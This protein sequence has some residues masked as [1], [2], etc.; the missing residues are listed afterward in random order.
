MPNKKYIIDSRSLTDGANTIFVALVSKTGNG[1]LYIQSLYNQGVRQFVVNRDYI[2]PEISSLE[3]IELHESADTLQYLRSEA[4]KVRQ[5]LQQPLVA[6]TGSRG[7]TM[8]KEWINIL[9][10]GKTTRSPRS[11]NSQIGVPLSILNLDRDTMNPMLLEIGISRHGEMACQE[12][13]ARPDIVVLTNVTEEHAEGFKNR[14]HQ[15]EEKLKLATRA[16]HL[17]YPKGDRE[18]EAAV[19]KL[20]ET[21]NPN[22]ATTGYSIHHDDIILDIQSGN[23]RRVETINVDFHKIESRWNTPMLQYHKNM[24][25]AAIATLSTL[26]QPLNPQLLDSILPVRTRINLREGLNNSTI[27]IDSFSN[28]ALS[29]EQPLDYASRIAAQ[30]KARMLLL[31]NNV[32]QEYKIPSKELRTI[33]A[34]AKQY[35]FNDIYLVDE[36]ADSKS[37]QG[38]TIVPNGDTLAQL[39]PPTTLDDALL[40]V[41]TPLEN[42]N[43]RQIMSL[44]EV[45]QN[46]TALEI[47]IDALIHNY[48]FF[49]SGLSKETGIICMLK[50]FGYGT[51]SVEL[52]RALE[53][54]GATALA[55]AVVDEAIELRNKG[56]KCPIIVLNP[57]TQSFDALREYNLEPVIYNFHLLNEITKFVQLNNLTN[58]PVHIKFETGMRRI[59]FL[60]EELDILADKIADAPERLRVLT[61]FSHLAT[62]DC[63]DM[64][65]YTFQQIELF[66]TMA[67]QFET[68]IGYKIKRHILNSAGILRFPQ[69]QMD[70]V[71]LGI[72]LYGIPTLPG[73]IESTLRPIASLRTTVM[74]VK[75]WNNGLT[76]GY[77]CRGKLHRDSRIATIPIGYADGLDRRLG[78]GKGF[79]VINN[80]KCPF[81]GNICMDIAM[82]DVTDVPQCEVGTSVE[83][84]GKAI[85]VNDIADVLETIPY[86][87]LTSVSKR[88]NRIYYRE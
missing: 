83:I 53:L 52:A 63:L 64:D 55:V 45:Q 86:E 78:N 41:H 72:G 23:N 10:A 39:L 40:L 68:R 4:K 36:N 35:G 51:G 42:R 18:I 57:R 74:S 80:V 54:Q 33:E 3:G 22:L 19:D 2:T 8:V 61:V 50:A 13:V 30:H 12:D 49:K 28:D 56:I 76:V 1:H 5:S 24:L 60:H 58:F 37:V 6:I 27:L 73:D 81:V 7:K 69:A 75:N 71:R 20:R 38:I 66:K 85:S 59:G 9:L 48:N 29:L 34:L 84:F 31:F 43:F 26:K 46:E 44:Y 15:I 25:G 11:Y 65:Q 32:P 21:I 88:V 47:N 17:I 70:M 79:V 77:G 67:N 82:V 62:A 14:H 87:I 16:Q